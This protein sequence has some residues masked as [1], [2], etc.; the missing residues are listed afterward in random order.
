[1]AFDAGAIQATLTLD[2]TPFQAGLRA[3]RADADAFA[4]R[5]I[6]VTADVNAGR[7]TAELEGLRR[8][9]DRAS[10]TIRVNVDQKSITNVNQAGRGVSLLATAITALAPAAVPVL[11]VATAGAAGL[12]AALAGAGAGAGAFG[13]IAVT[14]FKKIQTAQKALTSAQKAYNAATTN[15]A[16]AAA[17]AKERAALAGLSGP[18]RQ[19]LTLLNQLQDA[20]ERTVTSLESPVLSA[21]V[22]WL[23]TARRALGILPVLVRPAATAIRQLGLV[24]QSDYG[25]WK[26]FFTQLGSFGGQSLGQLGLALMLVAHGFANLL[27]AFR[28]VASQMLAGIGALALR[29]A[30]WSDELSRN[31]GF[32][33][34]ISYAQRMIP[35]VFGL[36]GNLAAA[37]VHV[38]AS[39][40]PLGPPLLR[41]IGALSSLI[42]ALPPPVIQAIV[43][44]LGGFMILSKITGPLST[45]TKGLGLL[46]TSA[47]L[48]RGPLGLLGSGLRALAPALRG[49]FA[50]MLG[51]PIGIIITA[52]VALGVAFYEAYTHSAAFR[53]VVNSALHAVQGVAMAVARWFG[54]P[55]VGFWTKTL[56]HAFSVTLNWVR[57]NWPLLLGALTG[58]VGF[59]TAYIIT[60]WQQVAGAFTWL[61]HTATRIWGALWNTIKAWAGAA[62]GWVVG[63]FTGQ[64]RGLAAV[65]SWIRTTATRIWGAFWNTVKAWAS[66]AAAWVRG[67]LNREVRG[68]AAVFTWVR[69]T[70]TRIW[71]ALWNTVKAWAAAAAAWVRSMLNR[72]IRGWA[73]VFTWVRTTVSRIWG[74]FWN[75]VKSWANA[76]AQWVRSMLNREARGWLSVFNWIRGT[77]SAAW[78]ALWNWVQSF[79]SGA[80]RRVRSGINAFAF[81]VRDAFRWAVR[82]VQAA[83]RQVE[84]VAKAPVNFVIRWVYDS[85]IRTIW[86]KVAGLV[87]LGKLPYVRPLAAG[88]TVPASQAGYVTQPTA[89]VG[90]GA[91]PEYVIP[92]DPKYRGRALALWQA[93]GTQLMA[94]GGI[95]PTLKSLGSSAASFFAHPLSSL[96]HMFSGVFKGLSGFAT[97]TWGKAIGKIPHMLVTKLISAAENAVGSIAAGAFGIP[98]RAA[99]G[100]GPIIAIAKRLLAAMG[101]ANQFGAFNYLE[102]REAGY[103]PTIVNKSSGAYGIPQALPPEKM[104]SAGPDWRTNP[105][106][107]LRWMMGYIKS[108]YGSP[109]AAAAHERAYNWYDSGGVLPPG[110]TV[111]V[112]R[113]GRDEYVLTPDQ[114]AGLASSAAQSALVGQVNFSYSDDTRVTDAMRD[115]LFTLRRAR[116][117]VLR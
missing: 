95:V 105:A 18:E 30:N 25:F 70:A 106:T 110:T 92:T 14:A 90:E 57:A 68:W 103:N 66:A 72:E 29:F 87:H 107:Q 20:W 44:A 37:F 42:R 7:A 9:E 26:T 55:F 28:P 54:G 102:M 99:A 109:V 17:L 74:A 112:N 116:Q 1:M 47:E 63:M 24:A 4:K 3:A 2:R 22:P 111:A 11:A 27:L 49:L 100:S 84:N 38:A 96:Q 10:R 12:G 56:P 77:A 114:L 16:R 86:N 85:G 67:M 61:W 53:N 64:A 89:I 69:N 73:S 104:A 88:G 58:P 32:N 13:L 23:A 51:N 60:H 36:L 35:L 76:A 8:E 33:Q 108:R 75:T 79:A 65:F 40:A 6:T 94:A 91:A 19:A 78:R 113:T 98:G 41:V 52:L 80:W 34:F 101:W 50:I 43:I 45:F 46:R 82:A 81:G 5:K 48:G 21:L 93:A 115:L 71:G 15:K 83:W 31:K 39:L 97:S 59:A 117:G 62:A